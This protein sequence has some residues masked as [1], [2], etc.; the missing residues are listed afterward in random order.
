MSS[1]AAQV[2]ASTDSFNGYN[3]RIGDSDKKKIWGGKAI[4]TDEGNYVK[5]LQEFLITVGVLQ[6]AADGGFGKK[7]QTALQ[8]FQWNAKNISYKLKD[9]SIMELA[10]VFNGDVN[11][12]LDEQTKKAIARWKKNLTVCTGDLVRIKEAK[13]TN[14]TFSS[15]LRKIDSPYVNTGEL[16]VSKALIPYLDE[17][18]N[19][20]VT[21]KIKLHVN[22]ALRE[23]GVPPKGAVVTPATRSQHYLGHALDINMVDGNSWNSS[24]D[25]KNKKET[26]NAKKFIKKM[27]EF[28][29]RWGGD[30]APVDTPHFDFQIPADSFA[31]EAKFFFNQR[32]IALK[33]MI[34]LID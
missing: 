8:R 30:F 4:A 31:Y 20:A 16:V 15:S 34:P 14:I 27:K 10:P 19:Q 24:T 29:M 1:V 6:E 17:M 32:S 2:P 25:F 3:L 5:T 21:L 9:K 33:S 26:D 12:I 7:T 11:G 13:Y 23:Q 28:G 22:Q 18:N